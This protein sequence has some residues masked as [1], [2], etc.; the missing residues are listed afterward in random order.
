VAQRGGWH[1]VTPRRAR[2]AV[3]LVC[4]PM[5][6]GPAGAATASSRASSTAV[7]ITGV[8][9]AHGL[10]M[11]MDGVEGQAR[12]GWSHDRILD[13]FYAGSTPGRFSGTI[14]VGLAQQPVVTLTLPSGGSISTGPSGASAESFAPGATV[15]I[16]RGTDGLTYTSTAPAPTPTPA[17]ASPTA[18]PTPAPSGL[19]SGPEI[20]PPTPGAPTPPPPELE[21]TPSPEPTPPP[22]AEEDPKSSSAPAATGA[23]QRLWVTG[24]GD[25]AL[26]RVHATGHRYRGAIEVAERNGSL[27]VV[28]HVDLETYVAG[29]AEEKGAG[30]PLEGL[31]VLAIAARSLGAATMTWYDKSRSNGYHI[32]PTQL[33]QVYLGYDGEE[34]MMR[35]ATA[36]TAGVIRTYNG[37]PILAMYH[38]NGGGQT[39]TYKR[40]ID[41]GGDPHPYLRSVKYPYADPKRWTRQETHASI[42]GSLRAAGVPVPGRLTGLEVL[43]RGD[44]PRVVKMRVRGEDGDITITGQRF[45]GALD[46]WSTWFFFETADAPVAALGPV[47]T[48]DAGFPFATQ[49]STTSAPNARPWLAWVVAML[50]FVALGAAMYLVLPRDLSLGAAWG[51]G[52]RRTPLYGS[53]AAS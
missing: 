37:R 26:V 22:P 25:P 31:K 17:K 14:T 53:D 19:L 9:T 46:L 13:L 29:I 6:V 8:G 4:V 49:D 41:Y 28:N 44:S 34:P 24:S 39:E 10:G 40:L 33:C 42:E 48:S 18:E 16:R 43:E 20:G 36:E 23:P 12:A 32:C 27:S 21:P 1:R 45:M 47:Y 50:A 35:R 15:T 11:A 52:V 3:A 51:L 2:V 7:T 38:G 30:W 5:V